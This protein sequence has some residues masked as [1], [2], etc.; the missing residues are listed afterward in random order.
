M[1]P[2]LDEMES[3]GL[4]EISEGA[5]VVNLDEY[6]MPPCLLVKADGASLYATRDIAAAYY[7]KK[8]YDFSKCLYV[9]AYH[10]NLH[11][12]QVFKVLE[13]MDFAG[14]DD[15]EHIAFGMVS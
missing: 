14:K 5:K 10:Q 7:R 15:M 1:Q 11:F 6:G 9:V 8:T 12:K 4:L 3:K 2:C 13:L